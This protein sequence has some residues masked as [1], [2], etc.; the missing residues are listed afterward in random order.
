MPVYT[1]NAPSSGGGILPEGHYQVTVKNAENEVSKSS[2]AEMIKLTLKVEGRPN[3]LLE[4]LVFSESSFWK[5]DQ[6]RSALGF[7]IAEGEE[8]EV[9]ADDFIGQSAVVVVRHG[10]FKDRPQ[11]RIAEWVCDADDIAEILEELEQ[12]GMTSPTVSAEEE[13]SAF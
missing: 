6:V 1:Q 2:G 7:D 8:V 12:Q 4:W 13:E 11:A 3:T 5:I 10:T 9:L